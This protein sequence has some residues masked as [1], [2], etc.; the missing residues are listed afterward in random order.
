MRDHHFVT[1]LF[2]GLLL[3]V[4]SCDRNTS[5][6]SQTHTEPSPSSEK[7]VQSPTSDT[8]DD[9][10]S[11]PPS[12]SKPSASDLA[13]D[14]SLQGIRVVESVI[15]NTLPSFM[16]PRDVVAVE[17][18]ILSGSVTPDEQKAVMLAFDQFRSAV[19]AYDA[20]AVQLLSDDSIEYYKN[21]LTVVT[22]NILRIR[23]INWSFLH[24]SAPLGSY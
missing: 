18:L 23:F 3:C 21:M 19:L 13:Q 1:L 16:T 6:T 12:D 11:R 17:Q 5:L 24:L 20:E 10:G 7:H 4:T 15:E 2:F 8:K 14:S 22:I 9:M